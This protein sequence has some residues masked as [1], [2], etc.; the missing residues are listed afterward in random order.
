MEK[1]ARD[2]KT[3]G[4]DQCFGRCCELLSRTSTLQWKKKI[5]SSVN[6][7][8]NEYKRDIIEEGKR[9]LTKKIK[10]HNYGI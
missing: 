7:E 8:A 2:P 5:K 6:S 1:L 3:S 9:T 10:K 4:A